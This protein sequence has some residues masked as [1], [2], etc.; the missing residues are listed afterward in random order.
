MKEEF[1]LILFS[2]FNGIITQFA[3]KEIR[4]G[5]IVTITFHI[6]PLKIEYKFLITISSQINLLL[7][8]IHFCEFF[9]DY[10]YY[11]LNDDKALDLLFQTILID[12]DKYYS[13]FFSLEIF[14]KILNFDKIFTQNTLKSCR[15]PYSVLLQ[16]ILHKAI[17]EMVV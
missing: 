1:I 15:K 5:K 11:D 12:F 17:N 14:T 9:L 13:E 8:Y 16:N 6:F 3:I 10:E 2:N 7:K 4:Q